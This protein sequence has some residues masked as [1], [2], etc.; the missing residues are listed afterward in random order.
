MAIDIRDVKRSAEPN[1]PEM[2]SDRLESIRFEP[3]DGVVD[4]GKPVRHFHLVHRGLLGMFRLIY[5]GKKVVVEKIG[6]GEPFGISEMMTED[7]SPVQIEPIKESILLR[8]SQIDLDYFKNHNGDW[9]TGMIARESTNQKS[10]IETVDNIISKELDQ[11][12]AHELL[13]L[14]N[15]LGRQTEEGIQLIIKFTRKQL[16][17]MIG[18]CQ[19]SVIRVLSEW[20]KNDLIKTEHKLITILEPE[21]LYSMIDNR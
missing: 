16:S 11:R 17:N 3:G 7:E 20:E 4:Q 9:L 21:R 15:R 12:L 19:E 6:P 2:V 5:P 13:D 18:C 1:V 8:G 10:V 14:A